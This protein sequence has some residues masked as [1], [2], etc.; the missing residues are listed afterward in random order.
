MAFK[1]IQD[2]I[3]QA[4]AQMQAAIVAYDH[5][6]KTAFLNDKAREIFGLGIDEKKGSLS[7]MTKILVSACLLKNIDSGFSISFK[8]LK[9]PAVPVHPIVKILLFFV[10]RGLNFSQSIAVGS[11]CILLQYL[12]YQFA[13]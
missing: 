9:L 8:Y 13:I 1:A 4:L 5:T 11:T 7:A 10:N 2:T 3:S 12:E 6:G